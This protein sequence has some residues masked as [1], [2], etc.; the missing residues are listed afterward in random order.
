MSQKLKKFAMY[1]PS[2]YMK[3]EWEVL[4]IS[5]SEDV[6]MVY[7]GGVSWEVDVEFGITS[8]SSAIMAINNPSILFP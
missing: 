2:L 4:K 8:W 1:A 5:L 6:F 3:E 7:S